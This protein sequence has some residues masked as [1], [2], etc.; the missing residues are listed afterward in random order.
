MLLLLFSVQPTTKATR[1]K[2]RGT[3]QSL[4][5]FRIWN[6]KHRNR[7]RNRMSGEKEIV[8]GVLAL[9]GMFEHELVCS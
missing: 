4:F 9:Q 8:I 2:A 5:L 3:K 6:L 7:N 1:H